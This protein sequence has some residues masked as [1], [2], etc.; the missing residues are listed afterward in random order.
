MQQD[1]LSINRR[2]LLKIMS[3]LLAGLA[4]ATQAAAGFEKQINPYKKRILVIGA[5]L[6]GLAA[7]QKLQKQ[8]HDVIVVEARNRIG[9]RIWTSS[10]WPEIPLDLG[11]TW[12]HGVKGNPLTKLAEKINAKRLATSYASTIVYNAVGAPLSSK[13][14]ARLDQLRRKVFQLLKDAQSSDNDISIKQVIE[15]LSQQADLTTADR[16][17]LSFILSGNIEQEY[18]G[19]A[20]ELSAHW[21]DDAK[22]FR[23]D[24]ALF[25]NGFRVIPEYLAQNLQIELGQSVKEI[26]WTQSPIYVISDKTE[27]LVDHVIVTLP[28]GVLKAGSVRFVPELPSFKQEAIN[29]LGMGVLN[30]CYLRFNK[31]FWPTDVD[32]LEYISPQHGEWTE[33]VSFMR[34]ANLPVLLGFNAA[35]LGREIEA[36]TDQQIVASAMQTLKTLYGSNVSEPLDYQITRW[37]SDPFTLGSYSFNA[38]GS[39]PLMRKELA[40][41]LNGHVHFAGEAS[42]MEHFSTAH[43]AY[44]SGVRAAE[45]VL[46]A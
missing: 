13:E 33:W 42:E 37:A 45:E 7:A 28:L 10:Q 38:V 12:I 14:E 6:A 44:L 4:T 17:F 26:H 36:W 32:W 24:D 3:V 46:S 20:S 5:G 30:K 31:A 18:S 43:G 15:T 11:A 16:Q 22:N 41:P 2:K 21:Y 8:G 29:Q 19:S 25:V 39:T 40:K 1:R 34:A 9:G 35:D 23:G 27:Y